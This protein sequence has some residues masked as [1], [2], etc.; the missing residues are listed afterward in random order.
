MVNVNA[1]LPFNLHSKKLSSAIDPSS[2][3]SRS[4]SMSTMGG[5]GLSPLSS[6]TQV[7]TMMHANVG[8]PLAP[9]SSHLS[10]CQQTGHEDLSRSSSIA[11]RETSGNDSSEN[12]DYGTTTQP[13][14]NIRLVRT[15][16]SSE[17]GPLYT[18]SRRGRSRKRTAAA[19][20]NGNDATTPVLPLL[21][22]APVDDTLTPRANVFPSSAYS[23]GSSSPSSDDASPSAL[24]PS[25]PMGNRP[26]LS[27]SPPSKVPFSLRDP[28]PLT[29]SWGD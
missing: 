20:P 9:F 8:A 28:G 15:L 26:A 14:F 27:I 25:S 1:R 6:T 23:A 21:A 18:T 3:S 10:N 11:S 2:S 22:G 4:A 13:L 24:Q 19:V 17:S 16:P 7:S 12:Y 5:P 29:V